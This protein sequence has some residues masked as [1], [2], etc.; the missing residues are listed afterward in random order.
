MYWSG[1]AI[2]DQQSTDSPWLYILKNWWIHSSYNPQQLAHWISNLP[3]LQ[4]ILQSQKGHHPKAIKEFML[5]SLNIANNL[6]HAS[7]Q[8]IE[9]ESLRRSLGHIQSGISFVVFAV[10]INL[11]SKNGY[12]HE[13]NEFM[14]DLLPKALKITRSN[15]SEMPALRLEIYSITKE[16]QPAKKSQVRPILCRIMYDTTPDKLSNRLLSTLKLVTHHAKSIAL[17]IEPKLVNMP[18]TNR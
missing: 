10:M 14:K 8:P 1:L 15:E 11:T 2:A 9:R 18:L 6:H 4:K 16:N 7:N 12:Q 17:L 13:Y 3:K 5:V